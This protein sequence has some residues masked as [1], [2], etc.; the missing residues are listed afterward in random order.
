MSSIHSRKLL[1]LIDKNLMQYDIVL[2]Y[3]VSRR[4][5]PTPG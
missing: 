3:I 2:R 4:Q 5:V 1:A